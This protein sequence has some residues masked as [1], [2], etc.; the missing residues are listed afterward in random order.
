MHD[1]TCHM[2]APYAESR[3]GHGAVG[4]HTR[5]SWQGPDALTGCP[6]QVNSP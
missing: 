3:Y 2:P 1:I 5:L 6:E 4:L